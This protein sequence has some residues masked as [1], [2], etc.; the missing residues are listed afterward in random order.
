MLIRRTGDDAWRQPASSAYESEDELQKLLAEAPGLLPGA[1]EGTVVV[2]EFPVSVGSIDLV[3]LDPTGGIT[4]CECKLGRNPEIRRKVMGQLLAYAGALAELRADEFVAAFEE[5]RKQTLDELFAGVDTPGDPLRARIADSL[6]HGSFRLVIAV[7][8]ITAELRSSINYL[9][10]HTSDDVEVLALEIAYVRDGEVEIVVPVT[11]GEEAAEQKS[12]RRARWS[13]DAL[14]EAVRRDG[15]PEVAAAFARLWS[16]VRD[17]A[18]EV[19]GGRGQHP[20]AT[21]RVEI[22]G[23]AVWLLYPYTAPG[24]PPAFAVAFGWAKGRVPDARLAEIAGYLRER[25]PAMVPQLE[26]LEETGFVT[27]PSFDMDVLTGDGAVAALLEMVERLG[28]GER[29]GG[30]LRSTGDE[31]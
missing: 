18:L 20:S 5:R 4:V 7:D 10:A 26:G 31:A 23:E 12:A 30:A 21:A 19:S 11:H 24:Y 6:S 29:L 16:G 2:R 8:E 13:D 22:D 25:I 28:A 27:R 14:M 1:G 3:G 9:N 17:V 15:T